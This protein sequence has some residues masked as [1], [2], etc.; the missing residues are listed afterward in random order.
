[1]QS[2]RKLL[3]GINQQLEARSQH[4]D[5]EED[6]MVVEAGKRNAGCTSDLIEDMMLLNEEVEEMEGRVRTART[7]LQQLGMMYC[8][9]PTPSFIPSHLTIGGI[10]REAQSEEVGE[11][12]KEKAAAQ[13]AEDLS[14]HFITLKSLEEEIHQLL[15][16]LEHQRRKE[17]SGGTPLS[18]ML[19]LPPPPPS[20]VEVVEKSCWL[21]TLPDK[22]TGKTNC[23]MRLELGLMKECTGQAK[24]LHRRVYELLSWS[25]SSHV[26][27]SRLLDEL[28]MLDF[29][30]VRDDWMQ[31]EFRS[32]RSCI[33]SDTV[34]HY[35]NLPHYREKIEKYITTNS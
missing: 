31:L 5:E 26:E 28:A 7:Q 29:A 10:V 14:S 2:K 3:L 32:G 21:H 13:L 18:Y 8:I 1:M 12:N 34:P 19:Q 20:H 35:F 33:K 27:W 9:I 30:S 23:E 15:S 22:L 11:K 17:E 24:A 6:E 25:Q 4:D 16:S